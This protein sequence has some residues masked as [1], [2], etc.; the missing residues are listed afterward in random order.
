MKQQIK[1]QLECDG[2]KKLF[3]GEKAILF[4][5]ICEEHQLNY[6]I[7]ENEN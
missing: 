5:W 3:E 2:C 7:K 6:I 4:S 1:V